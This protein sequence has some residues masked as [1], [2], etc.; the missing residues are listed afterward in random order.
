MKKIFIMVIV[1]VLCFSL[2]VGCGS[3][4]KVDDNKSSTPQDAQLNL[5]TWE[6]MFPQEVLDGFTAETGITINYSNFDYDETM[7]AKLQAAKGGDYDLVIADDYII[8]TVIAEG[9]A[10]KLDKSKLNN[11]S[12]I[13]PIYQ[14]QFYDPK[15]EYTVPYGAGIQTIVYDPA[16]I[17]MN[18][19]AYA[20]LWD[21]S[22][23]DSIGIIGNYRV[24][25][26]LALKVLGESYNTQDIAKIEAAGEKLLGLAP[27]IRLIKD[28]NLQ[29]DLLTGE[30]GVAVMYTS[31]VTIAKLSNPDL[32]VVFPSEGIGFGIMA[33]FIP[34]KAPHPDA[35]HK[36]I[37]YIL[38]PEVSAQCFEWLGYYC[39]N[40]AAEEFIS[41]E[42][43]D[44]LTLPSDFSGD[45]EMIQN[46][47]AEA[48]EAHTKVW[49][50]FKS[51][52]GK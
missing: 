35:A 1:L 7:L 26:G 49:T 33:G 29:D 18:I 39:T 50:K 16:L 24:I 3:S 52:M 9:L 43:K 4:G 17:D 23:K 47:G 31:Q 27:N 22:L 10:Q 32:K 19:T 41:E 28:D 42:Y 2:L 8:E 46:V 13:N 25:N 11:Y 34:S 36:F 51:E 45:M 40:K 48:E 21:S 38:Q 37:D 12:F 14:S 6:G 5:F 30:I 44:F 20:D 15:D